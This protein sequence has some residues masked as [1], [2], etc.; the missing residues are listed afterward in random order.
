MR[1]IRASF[2]SLLNPS[3]LSAFFVLVLFYAEDLH[4][5]IPFRHHL[6]SVLS[7]TLILL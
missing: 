7:N 1:S 3:I 6:R 2:Y 5:V 4:P